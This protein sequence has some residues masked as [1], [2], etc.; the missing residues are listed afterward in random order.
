VRRARR[1]DTSEAVG[2]RRGDASTEGFE[3]RE[4]NRMVR[5]PQTDRR[6]PTS[7]R[8]RDHLRT[9]AEHE[10]QRPGPERGGQGAR[11]VGDIAR[12][13]V[14]RRAGRDVDDHWVVARS[15]LHSVEPVQRLG[16][17]GVGTEPVHGLGRERDQATAPQNPN[18]GVDIGDRIR[19]Q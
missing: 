13:V 5:N 8:N 11:D 12:V 14:E 19:H 6:T 7:G 2:R 17:R 3:Q 4:R 10:R 9:L 18:R 15:P 16:I 1:A